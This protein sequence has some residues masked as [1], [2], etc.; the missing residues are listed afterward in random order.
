VGVKEKNRRENERKN[1]KNHLMSVLRGEI[2]Y[3]ISAPLNVLL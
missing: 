3:F 2:P 1:S